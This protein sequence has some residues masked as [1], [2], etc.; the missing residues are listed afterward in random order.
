M[1]AHDIQPRVAGKQLEAAAQLPASRAPAHPSS[2][3]RRMPVALSC[4][5]QK[6]GPS[7]N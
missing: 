1:A 6:T 4:R 2:G 5:R 7:H 3:E